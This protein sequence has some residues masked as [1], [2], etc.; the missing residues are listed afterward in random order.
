M[1]VIFVYASSANRQLDVNLEPP[2]NHMLIDSSMSDTQS[3][4]ILLSTGRPTEQA[5][6]M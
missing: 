4:H 6:T 5:L 2:D 1:Q 3:Q